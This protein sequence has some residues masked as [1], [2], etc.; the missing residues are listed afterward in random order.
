MC[1]LG[2]L[3]SVDDSFCNH[4]FLD[5]VSRL[6]LYLAEELFLTLDYFLVLSVPTEL[7]VQFGL[8]GGDVDLPLCGLGHFLWLVVSH[9]LNA[10]I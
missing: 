8:E 2:Q 4:N 5:S 3:E 7:E 6:S 9:L 1:T 10:I